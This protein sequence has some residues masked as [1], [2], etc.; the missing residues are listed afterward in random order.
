MAATLSAEAAGGLLDHMGAGA[1]ATCARS[2]PV[3]RSTVAAEGVAFGAC[4]RVYAGETAP[5]VT[6]QAGPLCLVAQGRLDNPE[7]LMA[8][9]GFPAVRG[10]ST[11]LALDDSPSDTA[12]ILAAYQSFGVDC[13]KHLVGDWAFVLWDAERRRLLLARDATG[14]TALYWWQGGG[15]LLFATQLQTLLAAGPVPRRPDGRWLAGLLTVFTDPVHPGAT[16]FEGV[17]AVPPGHLLLVQEG[18]ARLQRW[19]QP[20]ALAPLDGASLADLESRF[21]ALY[22]DAVRKRLRRRGGT[23]AS[24]LSGGLDS[25]SVVALAAPAL[26]EEGQRLRAYVHTPRFDAVDTVANR[27]ANEWSLAQATARFV[28]NVDAVACPTENLSPLDGIRRWLDFAA[29]PLGAA[30]NWYWLQDVA[31]QA[32][33]GGARVLF[34]GHG[35]N[36]TVSYTGSGNLWPQVRAMRLRHVLGELDREEAGWPAGLRDRLLKPALRP[37]WHRWKRKLSGRGPVPAWSSFSLLRHSYAD[38]L[39]L[40]TAMKLAQHDPAFSSTS[41]ARLA[42]FRLGLLG[43]ADNGNAVWAELGAAH[44][45]SMRDPTRDQRLVELCW[46][47]P[48]ELFWAHGR[49]RG[50]VRCSL[51]DRLPPEVLASRLKGQQSADLRQRLQDCR[52]DFLAEVEAVSRH[53]GARRV[54]DT[55]RLVLAAQAAV[56]ES[57]P[58]SSGAVPVVHLLQALAVA[59]FVARHA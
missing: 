24:T 51:R 28:G 9:L 58:P 20:E 2:H 45:L 11:A 29:A 3:L 37:A 23:V 17:N 43:G 52:A 35:G 32:C 30:A 47:L 38:E 59:M 46:R 14:I 10:S 4:Q 44:G 27:I 21:L 19:W 6:A 57:A 16:A 34:N 49:Q 54:I 25:G 40:D 50:L 55:E 22:D 33:A 7:E 39:G 18:R 1:E 36:A 42:Q 56:S 12:L 15:Q 26:A 53:A 8:L 5:A 41:A 31:T 48:D 13:V